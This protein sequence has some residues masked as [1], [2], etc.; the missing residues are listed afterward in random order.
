MFAPVGYLP[1]VDLIDDANLYYVEVNDYIWGKHRHI[2]EL[3]LEMPSDITNRWIMQ[4]CRDSLCLFNGSSEPIRISHQAITSAVFAWG[5]I[6][7]IHGEFAGEKLGLTY[8]L[9]APYKLCE[10]VSKDNISAFDALR[11]EISN[12]ESAAN[13]IAE[14][15]AA[16]DLIEDCGSSSE[17]ARPYLFLDHISYTVSLNLFDHLSKSGEKTLRWDFDEE[18]YYIAE[19]LR[20]FVGYSLCIPEE[21]YLK[22]W[23]IFWKEIGKREL[24]IYINE[25]YH[26]QNQIYPSDA[27]ADFGWDS[28][29]EK[30]ER[31]KKRLGR[32][33]S[34]AK[35]EYYRLY[36]N[37]K[38]D[39]I[40]YD[41]IEAEL[42]EAGYKISSRSIQYYESERRN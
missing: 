26:Y 41:A 37:G 11:R 30:V 29:N 17:F 23:K 18:V 8:E 39:G 24:Q 15:Q 14:D 1:L 42:L 10:P 35:E 27:G 22:N 40:S 2:S 6:K 36:P 28:A 38:P 12:E 9:L 7:Q 5:R 31:T 20:K 3:S 4:F 33:P 32:K 16:Y 21:L 13:T 34:G 25:K 19:I